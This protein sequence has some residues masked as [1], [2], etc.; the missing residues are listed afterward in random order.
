MTRARARKDRVYTL[1]V[2]FGRDRKSTLLI[3]QRLY[4]LA[5]A[6]LSHGKSAA[7]RLQPDPAPC[8]PPLLGPCL[9][10]FHRTRMDHG[11]FAS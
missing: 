3:A 2:K 7:L 5:K 11:E 8:P 10:V 6:L 4:F 9:F 1:A